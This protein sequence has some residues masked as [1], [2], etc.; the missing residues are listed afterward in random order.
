MFC[1]W[2]TVGSKRFPEATQDEMQSVAWEGFSM[3]LMFAA[4]E[5]EFLREGLGRAGDIWEAV[6]SEVNLILLGTRR[7]SIH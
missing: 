4:G 3:E 6:F 7:G 1:H 5:R 2:K